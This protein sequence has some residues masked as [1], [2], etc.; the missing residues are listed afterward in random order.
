M[1]AVRKFLFD[2]SFDEAEPREEATEVRSGPE[3]VVEIAAPTFGAEDVE[4]ARGEG[5]AAGRDD[6]SREA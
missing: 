6:A 4:T 1:A 5:Y 2:V 3:P